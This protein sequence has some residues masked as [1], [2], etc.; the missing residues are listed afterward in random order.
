MESM[1]KRKQESTFLRCQYSPKRHTDSV[2]LKFQQSFFFR[3]GKANPQ[4]HMELQRAPN[5]QN[6]P[7]KNKVGGFI[8]SSFTI[9]YSATLV[10]TLWQWHKNRL[11]DQ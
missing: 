4:V 8:L 9:Y 10:I 2:Q 1:L 6:N 11:T 3:N 5:S 7:K